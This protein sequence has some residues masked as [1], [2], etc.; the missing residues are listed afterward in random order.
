MPLSEEGDLQLDQVKDLVAKGDYG[1]VCLMAANNETG[2][3]HCDRNSS[4]AKSPHHHRAGGR[5]RV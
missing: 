2:V 5:F 3:L 4:W 1:L